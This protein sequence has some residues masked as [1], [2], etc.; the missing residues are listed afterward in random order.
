[1]PR[2][3][4]GPTAQAVVVTEPSVARLAVAIAGYPYSSRAAV[5]DLVDNSIE[6][7]ATRIGIRLEAKDG[8]FRRLVVID[9]GS[10]VHP[11]ILDEVLRAGSRTSHLYGNQSLSRYGIGLKGAGFSLGSRI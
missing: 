3:S 10:G 5:F 7:G 8:V 2:Q 9:N 4:H 6:A 1:M 11:A